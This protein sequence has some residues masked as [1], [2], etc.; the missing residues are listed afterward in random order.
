MKWIVTGACGFI[1][2]NFV[3]N[4]LA[5]GDEVVGV[6]NVSRPR[7]HHNLAFLRDQLGAQVEVG[8]IL[9]VSLLEQSGV[10]RIA[11][12]SSAYSDVFLVNRPCIFCLYTILIN[13]I[14]LFQFFI[15]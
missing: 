1:G 10:L 7:V 11:L 5:R 8:D 15:Y 6:D 13:N 4:L 9:E 14:S 3:E 12:L 2:T